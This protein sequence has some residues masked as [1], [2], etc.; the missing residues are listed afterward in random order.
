MRYPLPE[1][2]GNPDLLV[3]RKK[4]FRLLDRWIDLIPKRM[5]KSKVLLGRRKTGKTAIV[6]R[7]F[8]RL[9]SENRGIVPFYFSVRE[10]KI[11]YPDFAI[12]Y[13]RAFASQ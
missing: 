12:G 5:S 3:G 1:S 2:I 11:W 9:W 10:K 4:E 13:Y 6:Q 8:N 7:I